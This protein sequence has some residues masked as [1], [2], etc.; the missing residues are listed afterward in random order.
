MVTGLFSSVNQSLSH[1]LQ[2]RNAKFN[3]ELHSVWHENFTWNLILWLV[4]EL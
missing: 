4:A 3:R 1:V 2:Q